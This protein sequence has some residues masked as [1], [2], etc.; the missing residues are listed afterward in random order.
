YVKVNC[1]A[2][3]ENLLEAELFGYEKGAFTGAHE[4][5]KGF[6]EE[7]DGGTIFLDEIG[8]MS[9]ELQAKLL[10][11][12]QEYEIVR[13]GSSNAIKVDVRVISAT[14]RDLE[15]LVEQGKFR[16]DLFYRLHVV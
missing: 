7:A 4:Q 15:K 8:E 12:L 1:A 6:F 9:L 2:I 16:D 10:R 5:K 14:N 13:V 11:V 3:P